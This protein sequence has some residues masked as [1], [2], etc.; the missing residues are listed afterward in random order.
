MQTIR[1]AVPGGI[2]LAALAALLALAAAPRAAAALE[3]GEALRQVVA[4][5]PSLAA[6]DAMVEAAR[7]RPSSQGAWAPTMVEFGVLNIPEN[8]DLAMDDMTMT[9]L[10]VSQRVPLSGALGLRRRAAREA[11]TSEAAFADAWRAE[12]LAAAWEAYAEAWAAEQLAGHSAHHIGVMDRMASSARSRLESGRGQLDE[13]LRIEIERAR[14]EAERYTDLAALEGARARLDAFRGIPPGVTSDTLTTPAVPWPAAPR[15]KWREALAAHPRLRGLGSREA[16][17]RTEARAMRRMLWPDLDLRAS[18]AWRRDM[19]DGMP[20][21]DMYSL[22][23]ALMLPLTGGGRE[24]A[25]AAEMEA[26]SRGAALERAA[27]SLDL[28]AELEAT[29]AEA[30]AAHASLHL[31]QTRVVSLQGRAVETA[32]ASYTS[33]SG[34][35]ARALDAAHAFYQEQRDE[36]AAERRLARAQ[37]RLLVLTARP[38]LLG[39]APGTPGKESR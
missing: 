38:E 28:A 5:N 33:G 26:M 39:L 21:D 13:V 19:P 20:R 23:A 34:D 24:R 32:I 3:L 12:L 8:G 27:A 22:S 25:E 9:M 18:Y 17:Y 16:G 31:L 29:L 37:A 1:A 7:R 4:A 15:P 2:A 6:R 14:I 36:V 30:D 11:A 35:L 10:G